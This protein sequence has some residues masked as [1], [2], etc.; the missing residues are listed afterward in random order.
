MLAGRRYRLEFDLGQRLFA[1][2]LGGICRSVWNTG[3]EQRRAYRRRGAFIGY[4]EQCRQLAEAKKDP[5]CAWLA[6][7][8]AQVIQQT[9][10]DLDRAC[11][12]HGTWKVRWKSK[13]RWRP[14]FRFPT[15]Q[16]IPVEKISRKWGR[17]FL[18]KFGWVKFRMSRP[19]GGS[20]KSATVARDGRHWFIS[21]LV[22]D[23]LAEVSEHARPER[24]AGV[25]RGVATAA[26]T[27]D[28]EFF[29]RRH[30]GESSVSSMAPPAE[31][32]GDAGGTGFLTAGEARRYL[33]LQ[34]RLARSK[35]GSN[36]RR[37]VVRAM[38]DLM[39][40]ARWRRA[41]FNAQAAHRLTRDYAIVTLE[42]LNV[43]A[44]TAS[45]AP[46]PDPGAPGAYLPNGRAAKAGL[47]RSILDKGWYGL[48]AAL[49]SKARSAAP[50]IQETCHTPGPT[51][52]TPA[53]RSPARTAV[54]SACRDGP[55]DSA[56]APRRCAAAP[57]SSPPSPT[58]GRSPTCSA[59]SAVF[60]VPL[61]GDDPAAVRVVLVDEA[62]LA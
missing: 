13:A 27:S 48:E 16:Q 17:V 44:M 24:H 53:G 49:R 5:D 37:R 21:F 54:A 30:A 56:T 57:A 8:S 60:A 38:G 6:E 52:P 47:N 18:P 1:E 14:S 41:D 59:A 42:R 28:G 33:R 9:L 62:A 58:A 26:V 50:A 22:D 36:R 20:V 19:L 43:R 23:G 46:R 45:V 4:A 29:D 34:R 2:R 40:R 39:R 10:K 61:T 55:T 3:L 25:D 15:A 31:T 11:R 35:K 12:E 7:A 32:D 51:P